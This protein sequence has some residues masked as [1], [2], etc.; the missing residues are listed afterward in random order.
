MIAGT[1][2]VNWVSL[3]PKGPVSEREKIHWKYAQQSQKERAPHTSNLSRVP[4]DIWRYD[5]ASYSVLQANFFGGVMALARVCESAV[6]RHKACASNGQHRPRCLGRGRRK[7]FPHLFEFILWNM[8]KYAIRASGYV[9]RCVGCVRLAAVVNADSSKRY[10]SSGSAA[11]RVRCQS[12]SAVRTNSKYLF[13]RGEVP[14]LLNRIK[15]QSKL[16]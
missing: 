12:S 13:V 9:H 14:G 8:L 15:P 5:A 6:T 16:H 1:A 7:L 11:C 4:A 3:L 10:F 2:K